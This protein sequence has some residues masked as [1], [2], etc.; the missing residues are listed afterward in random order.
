MAPDFPPSTVRVVRGLGVDLAGRH[1]WAGVVVDDRGFCS[2][3]VHVDL[4]ALVAEAEAEAEVEVDVVGVDIPIGLIDGP[5]RSC[6]VAARQF[7]GPGR[8]SSVFPAP[9]R[10]VLDATDYVAANALLTERGLPKLSKQAFFLLPGIRQAAALGAER[11]RPVIE[12]F[13]EATFRHLAGRPLGWYKKTWSG[14]AQR[15]ELLAG[16]DPPVVVPWELGPV[17]AVP[18]DDVL[19]AAAVAWSAHR[20]AHGRAEALGAPDE[21]DPDTG[22]RIATWY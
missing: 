14:S 2:A 16:A 11:R 22:R 9:P 3:H 12:A 5:R 20:H 7:V 8:R 1:G 13:P 19:D 18:V 15:R 21:V 17:G 4:A 6:D 10:C